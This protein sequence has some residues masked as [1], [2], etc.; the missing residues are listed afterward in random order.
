MKSTMV[1]N[2]LVLRP[3]MKRKGC[4]CL[5]FIF[6]NSFLKKGLQEDKITLW[7]S[8]WPSSQAR[9]TSTKS[10]SPLSC[11]NEVLIFSWKSF[12]F[13]QN[14]SSAFIL[15]QAIRSSKYKRCENYDNYRL[16]DKWSKSSLKCQSNTM[17]VGTGQSYLKS[18][19]VLTRIHVFA[20]KVNRTNLFG[21]GWFRILSN[22]YH[23]NI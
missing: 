21:L 15:G 14:I 6:L 12:H 2:C 1:V 18:N 17:K 4:I 22:H 7:A 10:L 16:G 3:L 19:S 13:R 11:A 9:V 5:L 20:N 8:S 23:Y